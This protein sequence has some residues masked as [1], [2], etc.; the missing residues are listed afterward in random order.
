MIKINLLSANYPKQKSGKINKKTVSA[1]FSFLFAFSVIFVFSATTA[2]AA[3]QATSTP[4][5]EMATIKP[6]PLI[7][8]PKNE[9]K[10]GKP[11]PVVSGQAEF[12]D[13]ALVFIDEIFNGVA[14]IT[15]GKFVYRPFLPLASGRH[16]VTVLARDKKTGEKSAA[17]VGTFIVA[18]NPAPTLLAPKVGVRL[19]QSRVWVGGVTKNNSRVKILVD[20]KEYGWARAANHK[21]GTASFGLQLKGLALGEHTVLA[22]ARDKRGKDSFLSKALIINV[23]PKTPAPKLLRPVVNANAGIE[24]PFIVGLVKKGLIVSVV[25]DGRKAATMSTHPGKSDVASFAWQPA[26]PLALGRH[27]IEAFASDN[28]KFSNNSKPVFWQVGEIA[29]AGRQTGK[30]SAAVQDKDKITVKKGA[31]AGRVTIKD[32]KQAGRIKTDDDGQPGATGAAGE[33]REAGPGAV[34]RDLGGEDKPGRFNTSLIIGIVILAFLVIS[35]IIWYIQG[36]RGRPGDKVMDMFREGEEG[37]MGKGEEKKGED[38]WPINE[39]GQR[40]D[41]LDDDNFPPPPPPMF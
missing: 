10:F 27:K 1:F 40:R 18:A 20:Q 4:A 19:G 33:V 38:R 41:E 34:A 37:P 13:E 7:L 35:I 8:T 15:A 14:P 32:D 5:D 26:K 30:P 16:T 29:A 28:G 11:K 3:D 23:L 24:R 25:I 6:F 17:A 36:R 12:G 21:S 39:P 31:A 9:Q 2:L 22:L